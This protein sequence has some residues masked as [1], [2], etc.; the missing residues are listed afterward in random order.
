MKRTGPIWDSEWVTER[1]GGALIKYIEKSTHKCI[2]EERK[3][4]EEKRGDE[5]GMNSLV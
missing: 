3:K 5:N 1:G 4:E 2:D